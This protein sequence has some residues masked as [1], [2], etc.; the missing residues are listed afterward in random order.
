M[1]VLS[2]SLGLTL[3]CLA[4][5][6]LSTCSGA[7]PVDIEDVVRTVWVAQLRRLMLD[8]LGW[9]E[10]PSTWDISTETPDEVMEEYN[11]LTTLQSPQPRYTSTLGAPAV[12]GL[13][14]FKGNISKV[15]STCG[16]FLA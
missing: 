7:D 4:V 6:K 15:H 2:L 12:L 11:L 8:Q 1:K 5:E 16:T 13:K 9:D 14:S 3:F 10:I